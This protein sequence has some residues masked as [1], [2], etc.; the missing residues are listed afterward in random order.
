MNQHNFLTSMMAICKFFYG[1]PSRYEQENFPYWMT[2]VA[3]LFPGLLMTIV[4]ASFV[5]FMGPVAGGIMT[6][7]FIPLALEILT[8]WRGLSVTVACFER[9]ISRGRGREQTEEKSPIEEHTAL[10]QKQILFASLYL[11]RMA[12]FGILAASGNAVWFIYVLG[13]A[14]LIR[15]ELLKDEN[16]DVFEENGRYG[17]WCFYIIISLL[18]A[19]LSL[20]WS[21]VLSF[22]LAVILTAL[23]L[24]GIRRII[25]KLFGQTDVWMADLFGYLAENLLFIM[26]L[27]LFGREIHG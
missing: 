27:I 4:S 8:G 12:V 6:A 3:G 21:A 7:I 1:K 13:G 25:D 9:L 23:L 2:P 26:A 24:L 16:E 17:N 22:P 11:F 5:L 15:G 20:H 10:M 19:L 14:Y 18:A